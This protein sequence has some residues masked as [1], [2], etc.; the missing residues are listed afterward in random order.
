MYSI[1]TNDSSIIMISE[2]AKSGGEETCDE[3]IS[4][5]STIM[6]QLFWRRRLQKLR[7]ALLLPFFCTDL[8]VIIPGL[9]SIFCDCTRTDMVL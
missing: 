6:R 7:D 3:L 9:A 5:R 8:I 4:R 1:I 2:R